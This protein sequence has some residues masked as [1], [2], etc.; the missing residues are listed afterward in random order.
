MLLTWCNALGV[1]FLSGI[2]DSTRVFSDESES[3][4]ELESDDVEFVED[5]EK[6]ELSLELE[7]GIGSSFGDFRDFLILFGS[8]MLSGVSGGKYF[9]LF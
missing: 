9:L 5:E 2:S 7:A 8:G 4:S 3:L 6:V 1:D